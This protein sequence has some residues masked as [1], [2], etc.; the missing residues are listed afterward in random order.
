MLQADKMSCSQL[1]F[2]QYAGNCNPEE[3]APEGKGAVATEGT[4]FSGYFTSVLARTDWL[5]GQS[6][7]DSAGIPDFQCRRNAV[8]TAMRAA[9][10]E[11]CVSL[12]QIELLSRAFGHATVFVL[13]SP[14]IE[15]H[16]TAHACE[17]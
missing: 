1:T 6:A 2:S 7:C 3:Q 4:Y 9:G 10:G 8:T 16:S 11:R 12:F 17:L 13:Y 5:L 15:I 14:Q